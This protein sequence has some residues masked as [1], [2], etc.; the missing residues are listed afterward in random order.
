VRIV[1][2]GMER[3]A[4]NRHGEGLHACPKVVADTS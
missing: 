3:K 4:G 1:R 2:G